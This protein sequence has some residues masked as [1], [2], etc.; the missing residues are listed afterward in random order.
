MSLKGNQVDFDFMTSPFDDFP[1][2]DRKHKFDRTFDLIINDKNTIHYV[3]LERREKFVNHLLSILKPNGRL[4]L[5]DVAANYTQQEKLTSAQELQNARK[6]N[7]TDA[8]IRRADNSEISVELVR[9]LGKESSLQNFRIR[10]GYENAVPVLTYGGAKVTTSEE[11][12]NRVKALRANLYFVEE[13]TNTPQFTQ[14][15]FN[16][17]VNMHSSNGGKIY[18]LYN[19]NDTTNVTFM[20]LTRT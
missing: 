6:E 8:I 1:F 2:M 18:P 5:R 12:D 3:P 4:L 7:K 14:N 19:P 11:F 10:A 13:T 16:G 17:A 9:Q 15:D 20:E